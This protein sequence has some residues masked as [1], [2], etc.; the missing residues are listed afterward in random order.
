MPARWRVGLA[1]T[2]VVVA[3][4]VTAGVPAFAAYTWEGT[5]SSTFGEIKMNASG[6]GTYPG[7]TISGGIQ[8]D[9]GR[10]NKGTW[11]ESSSN[12]T[13]EFHMS[14]QGRLFDGT[15]ER[16]EGGCVFP[17]CDW[18]GQ[19]I[20]GPC[21]QNSSPEANPCRDQNDQ[22]ECRREVAFGFD[23]KR[24][25][26]TKPPKGE[27][28]EKL[29][30]IDGHTE[31]ARLFTFE[32]TMQGAEWTAAGDL[33]LTTR[34]REGREIDQRQIKFR[35]GIDGFYT[36]SGNTLIVDAHLRPASSGDENCEDVASLMTLEVHKRDSG[37]KDVELEM[38][39]R[40]NRNDEIIPCLTDRQ[41][42][43]LRWTTDD[44]K[45][46]RISRPRLVD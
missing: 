9:E 20:S 46:V 22:T 13:Y 17:P 41:R 7:G 34:Y 18:D 4:A 45:S 25:L 37:K 16:S 39:S 31:R 5:W 14:E 8:G 21:L 12:G 32:E 19:C 6:G 35:I 2:V 27:L 23:L 40:P 28:P 42:G 38:K 24:G 11:K 43:V 26:P 10:T 3:A 29:V 33:V 1:L 30:S 36:R 44:F 15:Y